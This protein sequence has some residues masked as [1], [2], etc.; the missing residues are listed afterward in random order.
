MAFCQQVVPAVAPRWTQGSGFP[1]CRM[2]WHREH[3]LRVSGGRG[4]VL[5]Q[6][7]RQTGLPLRVGSSR[8]FRT[9]RPDRGVRHS[10]RVAGVPNYLNP[11]VNM[12]ENCSSLAYDEGPPTPASHHC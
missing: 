6:D 7:S 8:A 12:T 5:W 9:P 10:S 4:C 3:P 11:L 2:A 1:P